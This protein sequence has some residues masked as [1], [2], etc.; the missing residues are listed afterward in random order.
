LCMSN[1]DRY[2]SEQISWQW[3]PNERKM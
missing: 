2:F 1:W 3:K